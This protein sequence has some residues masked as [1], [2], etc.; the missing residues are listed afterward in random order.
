M[1]TFSTLRELLPQTSL[2]ERLSY[3][4]LGI[5]LLTM[6]SLP[7]AYWMLGE[8]VLPVG[9]TIAAIF[10][11]S[12]VF[13]IVQQQWTLSRAL[14]TLLLVAVVTWAAEFIGH[15]T[16]LPFGEYHYTAALQPQILGVP[17]LIPVAWFM[18]LPSVWALAQIIVGERRT[19]Q[20]RLAF[21]AVSAIGLTVW[22]LFLDPQM[23]GWSFWVWENPGVYF[24]I[25][26]VNYFGWLLV[27]ALVTWLVDPPELAPF[28]LV[29]VYAAVWFLQSVGQAVFWGQLGPA[30]FGSLSMGAFMLVAYWRYRESTAS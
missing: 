28:P 14:R 2:A 5:W 4:L 10:Q 6:I 8:T 17:L 9:I 25:P 20:D 15:R 11:A 30:L 12:A 26:A 16:G 21:A 24:G 27:S 18:L 1:T 19:W 3:G 29:I 7:I 13:Y 23:V 22:D